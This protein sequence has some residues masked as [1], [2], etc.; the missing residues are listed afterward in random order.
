MN[1]TATQHVS[2]PGSR[3]HAGLDNSYGGSYKTNVDLKEHHPQVMRH[4]WGFRHLTLL[5]L[6][7]E[8]KQSSDGAIVTSV[9]MGQYA[10]TVL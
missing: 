1:H 6:P 3:R 9:L 8:P 10:S 4:E 2:F 7:V 5:F